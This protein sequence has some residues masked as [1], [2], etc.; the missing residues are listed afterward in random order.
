MCNP[1]IHLRRND[2]KSAPFL[3]HYLLKNIW[4]CSCDT[5][6]LHTKLCRM[7]TILSADLN[8]RPLPTRV[9]EWSQEHYSKINWCDSI[10]T[11]AAGILPEAAS[12]ALISAILCAASSAALL[13]HFEW[14]NVISGS[15]TQGHPELSNKFACHQSA[16]I[17]SFLRR[18]RL[19]EL[20][21]LL[22]YITLWY[23]QVEEK[24]Q[25]KSRKFN[26]KWPLL[27]TCNKL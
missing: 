20:A 15:I 21:F 11:A 26:G 6:H 4:K 9:I 18:G 24:T 12:F 17:L 22:G 27:G 13:K 7:R 23:F 16:S 8:F 5:M 14:V 1:G 2:E 25:K 10:Q 19:R 3:K